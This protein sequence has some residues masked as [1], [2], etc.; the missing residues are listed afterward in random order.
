MSFRGRR[1]VV[2]SGCNQLVFLT[3][4]FSHIA[5][6]RIS[7]K[8]PI[9]SVQHF[10]DPIVL[11]QYVPC[12]SCRF[13]FANSDSKQ[14]LWCFIHVSPHPLGSAIYCTVCTQ[15]QNN[16]H[17]KVRRGP[18]RRRAAC[19]RLSSR[20]LLFWWTLFPSID[21]LSFLVFL[22]SVSASLFL[23]SFSV[24]LH[25]YFTLCS[26]FLHDSFFC[27]TSKCVYPPPSRVIHRSPLPQ[28]KL[29]KTHLIN[30]GTAYV[31]TS[32]GVCLCVGL[33]VCVS[34]AWAAVRTR[35]TD[36]TR[37]RAPQAPPARQ[38]TQPWEGRGI[39]YAMRRWGW[40]EKKKVQ[41]EKEEA[42]E[43]KQSKRL[44]LER[45]QPGGWDGRREPQSETTSTEKPKE[46]TS[47]FCWPFAFWVEEGNSHWTKRTGKTGARERSKQRNQERREREEEIVT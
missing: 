29:I 11:Q 21:G 3:L 32:W 31:G 16:A 22:A 35:C 2:A 30:S 14:A 8:I 44:V 45:L 25:I 20:V 47:V 26:L 37:L 10:A 4:L 34:S 23:T 18:I 24:Q 39:C 43:R 42:G 12:G 17:F 27:F 19:A 38:D 7:K 1:V 15:M 5:M 9:F 40:E 33:L 41:E 28:Q 13:L 6:Y 36:P 46:T